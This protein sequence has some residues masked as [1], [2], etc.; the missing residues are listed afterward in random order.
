M[1]RR[2]SRAGRARGAVVLCARDRGRMRRRRR[3]APAGDDRHPRRAAA[4]AGRPA[5]T[6]PAETT[7]GSGLGSE[8]DVASAGDVT[9]KL[10]WLGDLEAPGIEAW[11]DQMVEKFQTEY[12]NV[13]VETT[14]YDTGTW[15]QTQQTACQSRAARTSGTTGAGPGRS[16]SP[17]RAAP[18]RTRRCSPR[19]T[20]MRTRRSRRR[21]GRARPGS[22]RSTSSSTRSSSTSI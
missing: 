3:E 12:P 1:D 8:F 18:S 15:I 10:W 11:M 21:S 20:S 13:T 2:N 7:R 6:P 19:P 14:L 5:E 17:G 4:P 22:S 16:S 9:L